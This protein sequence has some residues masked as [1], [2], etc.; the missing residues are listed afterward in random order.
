MNRTDSYF[1]STRLLLGRAGMEKLQQSRIAVVGLGGVGSHAAEALC[2]C[3]IGSISMIDFDR[4]EASNINRQLPA[5]SSTLGRYKTEVMAERMKQINPD[6]DINCFTCR[7]GQENSFLINRESCDYVVDAIDS[8]K[9]K[10]H[11]I[12]TCLEQEI[13]IISSMGTANRIDPSLLKIA[14][15]KD[16]SICPVAR[17][18]RRELRKQGIYSGLTVVY[19]ME[20]PLLKGLEMGSAVYVTASAGLLLAAH[21]VN[22]ISGQYE[23]TIREDG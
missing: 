19:S 11:L 18:V 15:I 8:I 10:I 23:R 12:K 3:G 20:A 5:L 2:R 9:D 22:C 14:D 17:R 16:T 13:P 4:V 6:L 21:T 1:Q 7:Y